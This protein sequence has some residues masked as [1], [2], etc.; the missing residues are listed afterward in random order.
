[1]DA[2]FWADRL[3]PPG[4]ILSNES[5][6]SLFC[7]PEGNETRCVHV[8]RDAIS[9]NNG[10]PVKHLGGPDIAVLRFLHAVC[11]LWRLAAE[12]FSDCNDPGDSE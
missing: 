2:T 6:T 4:A 3:W 10:F 12:R 9:F 5:R 8:P 7:S 11:L 1:M